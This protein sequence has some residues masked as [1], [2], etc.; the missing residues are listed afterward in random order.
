MS[1]N[2]HAS[3]F[4]LELS[5][6]LAFVS[7]HY[8]GQTTNRDLRLWFR[9]QMVALDSALQGARKVGDSHTE[10][11][12]HN[13]TKL[14]FFQVIK[15]ILGKSS[16][17][18]TKGGLAYIES[19]IDLCLN[20]N[21]DAL[22]YVPMFNWLEIETQGSCNR[23]CQTCLRQTYKDKDNL[24]HIGRLPVTSTVGN[25]SKMPFTTYRKIIDQALEMGFN[26][27]VNLQ[28]F[29]EPLLDERLAEFAAYAK[30]QPAIQ[31]V[32]ACTNMDLITKAR[33]KELDGLIDL[34]KVALYIPE[35]KQ[36]RREEYLLS[37]FKKT[38]LEFTKGIHVVTHFDRDKEELTNLIQTQLMKPCTNYT[39]GLYIGFDGTVLHCCEDYAGHFDLGNVNSMDLS[40][41]WNNVTHRRL[42]RDLSRAGG[43]QKYDYCSSCPR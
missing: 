36:P 16:E 13:Q 19:Q 17:S 34:F 3:I 33:A 30:S 5:E 37:L 22:P 28:H 6:A 41:I 14:E 26:G 24:T 18:G 35:H 20:D 32:V 4:D 40:S 12:A 11:P 43:R 21:P 42:V 29:N 1:R 15:E 9:Q 27:I 38:R 31:G 8:V 2:G 10:V 39:L 7:R 23:S 25:G